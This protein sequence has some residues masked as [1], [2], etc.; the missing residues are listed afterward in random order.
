MMRHA[1]WLLLFCL[2]AL[3]C[4]GSALR[5]DDSTQQEVQEL[6]ARLIELQRKSA[7]NEVELARL[8]QQVAEMEGGGGARPASAPATTASRSTSPSA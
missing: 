4:A 7:M 6:R 2:P 1:G 8:R 3:G 5:P